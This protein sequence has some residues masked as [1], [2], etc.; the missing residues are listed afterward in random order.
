MRWIKKYPIY[1][2]RKSD[3]RVF[4]VS[5]A[6][7]SVCILLVCFFDDKEDNTVYQHNEEKAAF[8]EFGRQV[9]NTES[10]RISYYA[11]EAAQTE[12]FDFDPNTADSTQFLRLGLKPWQVR[13]IYKYRARGGVFSK[14]SDFARVYGLTVKQYK[15]LEPHI[16]I[17]DD[18]LPAGTLFENGKNE[19]HYSV[20][21]SAGV[22]DKEAFRKQE[23]SLRSTRKLSLGQYVSVNTADTSLLMRIPGIGGYYAGAI[24]RYRDRLGGFVSLDQLDEIDGL[25]SSVKQYMMLE[26]ENTVRL[27]VNKLSLSALR[28]HPYMGFYRAKA[29]I[30]YR[31]VHGRIADLSD[32]SLVPDFTQ[33]AIR[34]LEPYVE[35]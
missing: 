15:A 8:R 9:K 31:R 6:I 35:Y 27:N 33:E 7:M 16:R 20:E 5:A 14:P 30:D 2:N 19:T 17:S 25:Q 10:G 26:T 12:L 23:D 32:L 3:R 34:R 18:Y 4:I 13:N 24:I 29:I 1:I 22:Y 28:R 21:T 11:V